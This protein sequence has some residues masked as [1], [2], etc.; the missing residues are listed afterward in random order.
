M[1]KQA[2]KKRN[3]KK[4]NVLAVRPKRKTAV[5]RPLNGATAYA[6][7][8]LNPFEAEPC[9][10]P[11]FPVLPSQKLRIFTRGTFGSDAGLPAWIWGSPG[12]ANNAANG[13]HST[14][15]CGETVLVKSGLGVATITPSNSPFTTNDITVDEGQVM[16]VSYG[17]RVRYIGS[18]LEKSGRICAFEQPDHQTLVDYSLSDMRSYDKGITVP[19]TR[20]WVAVTWQPVKRGE[21]DYVSSLSSIP[22][23]TI[24]GSC[25]GIMVDGFTGTASNYMEYEFVTNI[26]VIGRVARGKTVSKDSPVTAEH[27][28]TAVGKLATRSIDK[29]VNMGIES[30]ETV[31]TDPAKIVSVLGP[32]ALNWLRS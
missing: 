29:I 28:V 32:G 21:L 30:L 27:V 26:E 5:P 12:F 19:V 15:T 25:L 20:D 1:P 9:G 31:L 11:T 14:P 2:Q 3:T 10:V 16:C 24:A 22:F 4:K 7:L 13:W 8:L 6:A 18:E 17:I 23:S